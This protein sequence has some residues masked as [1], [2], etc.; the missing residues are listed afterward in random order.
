MWEDGAPNGFG[1]KIW[2]NGRCEFGWFEK[3]YLIGDGHKMLYDNSV[4]EKGYFGKNSV[5]TQR[6][7]GETRWKAVTL[8]AKNFIMLT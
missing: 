7:A 8:E 6:P 5:K 1:R 3:G 2:H 4:W